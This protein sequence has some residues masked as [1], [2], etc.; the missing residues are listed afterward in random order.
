MSLRV[1]DVNRVVA[2]VE[3]DSGKV[4][5]ENKELRPWKETYA[6]QIVHRHFNQLKAQYP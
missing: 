5:G 3:S 4:P 2:R 6:G 1:R